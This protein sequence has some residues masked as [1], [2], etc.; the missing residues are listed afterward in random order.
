MTRNTKQGRSGRRR[1]L[2]WPVA[3]GAVAPLLWFAGEAIWDGILFREGAEIDYQ[4]LSAGGVEALL[5]EREDLM[6]LD[7]R[8]DE[9]FAQGHLPRAQRLGAAA[10]DGSADPLRELD[11]EQPCLVYC[12]GGFRSRLTVGKM[13]ALGFR[14]V[15]NLNRGVLGWRLSGRE[16]ERDEAERE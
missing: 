4:N 7:V 11:R 5:A 15:Y 9:E 3:A 14:E 1:W 10:G 13:R 16:L 6:V 8:S 2:L 12:A